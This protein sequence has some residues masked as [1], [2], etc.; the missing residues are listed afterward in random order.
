MVRSCVLL[1]GPQQ[2][3]I[4]KVAGDAKVVYWDIGFVH[5]MGRPL[6]RLDILLEVLNLTLAGLGHSI[7]R[8]WGGVT[9]NLEQRWW[10]GVGAG[11]RRS[12][13]L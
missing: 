8:F 6:G 12:D 11:S 9:A 7:L 4:L 5:D 3:A 1:R 2:Q 10:V 13:P